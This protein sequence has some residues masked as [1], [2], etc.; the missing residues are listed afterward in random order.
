[1]A[2][3]KKNNIT[4]YIATIFAIWFVAILFFT[5]IL[6]IS[7][8]HN[9]IVTNTNNTGSTIVNA[10]KTW[11]NQPKNE[12][13]YTNSI[14]STTWNMI[15]I[16]Y[17]IQ[18]GYSH[19]IETNSSTF[20]VKSDKYNLSS[21]TDKDIEFSWE[22]IWFSNDDIPVL[23]ITSIKTIKNSHNDKEKLKKEKNKY[24]ATKW[25]IIDLDWTD[26]KVI[27]K[28]QYIYIN[29]AYSIYSWSVMTNTW[30]STASWDNS[31]KSF[32]KIVPY[33]CVKWSNLYDCDA[34]KEQA[35][36]YKFNTTTN[37]NWV[38]FYKIP[39]VSQY[40]VINKNYGYN[41]YPLTWDFFQF[42]NYIN[43]EDLQLK[44][45]QLIKNTCK[46]DKVEL[47]KILTVEKTWNNYDIIWFDKNANKILCKL[48][49]TWEGQMVWK[50]KSIFFDKQTTSPKVKIGDLNE[51]D[52]LVYSSKWFWY[53]LYMPKSTKYSSVLV[54]KDFWVSWLKCQQVT[55][56]A[57]WKTW[58][59][60]DPN[61]KAYYCKTNLSKEEI[62]WFLEN[63]I[64]KQN[65]WKTLI[66][67]IKS[68]SLS[69]KIASNIYIY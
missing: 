24:L 41:I 18:W 69:K 43:I 36:I 22:V 65:N 38:I 28:D 56:I 42:I 68:D 37:N 45:E 64:I 32:V 15:N 27:Q 33:K 2:R 7:T 8:N 23:N 48:T 47:T 50:L 57:D 19:K 67:D 52:Y 59:L 12:Q 35:K 39:E 49:I 26:F 58:N 46:N 61:V 55:K 63:Y 21:F 4:T 53:K 66:L 6:K 11:E 16:D 29:K 17:N 5:G 9:N 30:D 44:R 1:M 40:V 3:K 54:N 10:S 51:K 31:S 20:Y 14:V 13:Y 25:L 60:K 34:F 62:K